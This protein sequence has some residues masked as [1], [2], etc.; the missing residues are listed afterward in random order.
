[1]SRLWCALMHEPDPSV[2]IVSLGEDGGIAHAE[3][4]AKPLGVERSDAESDDR[5][6]VAENRPADGASSKPGD[7]QGSMT[8]PPG[9]M[10]G[11]PDVERMERWTVY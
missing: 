7:G 2:V 3:F 10:T 8:G 9:K 4:A 6:G 1:M 11:T 5:A